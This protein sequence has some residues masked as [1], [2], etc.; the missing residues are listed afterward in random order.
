MGLRI[1]QEFHAFDGHSMVS[2]LARVHPLEGSA[3]QG[4]DERGFGGEDSGEGGCEIFIENWQSHAA[5][6]PSTRDIA[7]RLDEIDRACAEVAARLDAHQR[8]QLVE[9]IAPD[10]SAFG[11]AIADAP[12]SVWSEHVSLEGMEHRQPLHWRLLDGAR[13]RIAGSARGWRVR[14]LPLGGQSTAPRGFELL[15][16]ADAPLVLAHS[17]EGETGPAQSHTQLIGGALTPVLRQPIARVIANAETI[18]SRLAGPL[19]AEYSEYAG[20]IA[21][22]GQ[23][24]NGLLDDLADL[25]VVE[26]EDFTTAHEAVDLLDAAQRAVGILGVRAQVRNIGLGLPDSGDYPAAAGEF[27][28]VLQILINLVGNA[29]AYSPAES[30]V[31]ISLDVNEAGDMVR[32]CVTDEG[33]G[34]DEEEAERVFNKFERL[35]REND[36]GSGLGLYISSRLAQAMGGELKVENAGQEGATFCLS[37]PIFGQ[38]ET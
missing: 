23:L 9:A 17:E 36:G 26:A 18:R 32:L 13:C 25:E 30:A 11:E 27:R 2:G 20:N 12:G 38:V 1:S 29:I 24:L 7:Q 19:R 15:L 33:P 21:A 14:L 34:I 37:L 10:A 3:A 35:G 22:A 31:R 28:R 5:P 16:I 4:S 6:E 8:V